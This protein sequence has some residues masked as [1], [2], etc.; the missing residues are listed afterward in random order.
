MQV[1]MILE[2]E[3][4]SVCTGI[5]MSNMF[6]AMKTSKNKRTFM[7]PSR[8]LFLTSRGEKNTVVIQFCT[9]SNDLSMWASK[10]KKPLLEVVAFEAWMQI[11]LCSSPM[12]QVSCPILHDVDPS[13]LL[14]LNPHP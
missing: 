9:I 7:T 12:L 1:M 4:D 11:F 5:N 14:S 13:S 6:A 10:C 3:Q 2:T 8:G